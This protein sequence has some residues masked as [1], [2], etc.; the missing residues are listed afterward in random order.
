VLVANVASAIGALHAAHQLGAKVPEDVSVIGVHDLAM[1]ARL[2]PPLTTVR[3][4]L[5]RLGSRAVELLL[6][7]P[8]DA[9]VREVVREPIELVPRESTAP[10]RD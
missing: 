5:E 1:A 8:A 10:P 2:V 7:R 6:E 3:M 4:P 9:D